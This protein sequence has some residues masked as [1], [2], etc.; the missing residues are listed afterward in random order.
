MFGIYMPLYRCGLRYIFIAILGAFN[1]GLFLYPIYRK[2]IKLK[3][4]A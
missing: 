1:L 3:L 4:I 2:I